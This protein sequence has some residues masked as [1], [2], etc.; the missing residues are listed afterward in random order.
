MNARVG[1]FGC[2]IDRVRMP[3]AVARVYDLIERED[4]VC[5]YVVTPNVDHVVMLDHHRGLQQAYADASLILADGMPVVLASRLLR[6]GLPERITGTDLVGEMLAAAAG[7]GGL[8]VFLLGAGPGVAE[9]AAERIASKWPAVDVVG[10]YSPPFGFEKDAEE[11]AHILQQI[12]DCR[13]DVLIVGLGAPKQELWVHQHRHEIEAR[14]ALCV[15]AAIDFLAE[16]KRRA[17]RWMQRAGLEWFHRMA[18]EPKRL[19]GRY[20][21]DAWQF[22]RLVWRELKSPREI[23]APTPLPN[24][25]ESE[26][27][28]EE[29][30]AVEG[31]QL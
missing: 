2:W 22:P 31:S 28:W 15:G 6:R 17:P 8:R 21:H 25:T 26:P 16:N 13:P 23:P 3:E 14:V 11:N 27:A 1:I 19:A 18:S 5:H 20:A 9:Q 24:A 4:D 12:A 10:T 7:N 30:P 29:E